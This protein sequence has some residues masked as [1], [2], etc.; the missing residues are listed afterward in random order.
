MAGILG[1]IPARSGSIGIPRKNLRLLAGIPLIAHTIKSAVTSR[2]DRVVVS[3]DS[4]EIMDIAINFNAECPFL[5]PTHLATSASLAIDVVRHTLDYYWL[6][7]KWRPDAVF[8]LQPTSPFR[9]NSDINSALDLFWSDVSVDSVMSISLVNEHPSFQWIDSPTGLTVAFPDL[10]RPQN[11]QDL[12]PIYI[13]NNAIILSRT[14]YLLGDKSAD[15]TLIN[16]KNFTPMKISGN[17]AID[18]DTEIQFRL[19]EVLSLL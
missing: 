15:L 16:Y 11:R 12:I 17:I 5:R 3:T 14:S 18:I 13:D 6:I 9:T 10:P 8:Y 19:A 1:I 7:E 2:I 4:K